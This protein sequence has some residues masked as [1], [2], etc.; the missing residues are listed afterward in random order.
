MQAPTQL[1]LLFG[2]LGTSPAA[3]VE[4][5]ELTDRLHRAGLRTR[6]AALL[7]S[8]LRLEDS[9]HVSVRRKPTYAFALTERGTAAAHDLGPGARVDV[10]VL[11]LDLVGFVAF[12]EEHGDDAARRA[13]TGLADAAEAELRA[14]GGRLVKSL[15][16]GVLGTLPAGTDASAAVAG[17]ARRCTR[18]DGSRWSVRAAARLGNPIAFGPDLYGAD[19]NLVSRLCAAAAPDE[20]VMAV[21]PEVSGAE[22]LEVR[23]LPTPVPVVRV[24]VP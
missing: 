10:V 2:L 1:D 16:D 5:G 15:G 3:P 14:R 19:V 9:G 20:L 13:A 18:P 17:I 4:G 24:P 8:L 11:M 23:G 7:T 6:P 12:T 21:G 22:R